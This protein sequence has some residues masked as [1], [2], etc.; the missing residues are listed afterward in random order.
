ME[1]A[2]YRS[3]WYKKIEVDGI[4][5]C[6]MNWM[7]VRAEKRKLRYERY[8]L[9]RTNLNKQISELIDAND[10]E[11]ESMQPINTNINLRW[12]CAHIAHVRKSEK[13]RT[14]ALACSQCAICSHV[15]MCAARV[16]KC[17]CALRAQ[18]AHI[19]FSVLQ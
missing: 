10:I 1:L 19:N 5:F 4:K 3:R 2:K 7:T 11:G 13:L 6:M 17:R 9:E 15:R 18:P 8:E 16:R 12:V 14:C